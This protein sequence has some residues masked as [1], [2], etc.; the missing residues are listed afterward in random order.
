M[1][2]RQLEKEKKATKSIAGLGIG[3]LNPHHSQSA[4]RFLLARETWL[5]PQAGV[6]TEGTPHVPWGSGIRLPKVHGP[7]PVPGGR[8]A[9]AGPPRQLRAAL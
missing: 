2:Y 5:P 1:D 8:S 3:R 6:T 7:R 4:L 9:V